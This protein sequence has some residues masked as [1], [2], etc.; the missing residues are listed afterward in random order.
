MCSWKGS[1]IVGVI[2]GLVWLIM[3]FV[4]VFL[5]PAMKE[6]DKGEKPVKKK[7]P[8]VNLC[9]ICGREKPG[10]ESSIGWVCY[11]CSDV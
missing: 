3:S 7:V 5:G 9:M 6:E 1:L 10:E 11:E 4:D 2:L 8:K